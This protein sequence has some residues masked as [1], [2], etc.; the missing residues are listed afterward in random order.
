MWQAKKQVVVELSTKSSKLRRRNLMSNSREG[1]DC[2]FCR[3]H[4]GSFPRHATVY[5]LASCKGD[6][7]CVLR[8]NIY[9]V[10]DDRYDHAIR[11]LSC[12]STEENEYLAPNYR[13]IIRK[14]W[15]HHDL[16]LG[17]DVS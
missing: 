15:I 11:N 17:Q 12:T 8:D 7:D 2:I 6:A 16:T 9:A 14:L 13:G 4:L 5:G 3:E 1:P 10:R